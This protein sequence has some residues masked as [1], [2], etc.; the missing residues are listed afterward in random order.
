M[1]PDLADTLEFQLRAV[2]INNEHDLQTQCIAEIRA[3]GGVVIRVNSG[4]SI[5]K[6]NRHIRLAD[7]GTSDTIACFRGKFIAAEIKKRGKKASDEQCDFLRKVAD[8][9]G[10]PLIIDN[11]DQLKNALSEIEQYLE[12]SENAIHQK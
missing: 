2:G 9:G 8:A 10:I 4:G 6:G 5:S 12:R 3:R 1:T 11:L 7:K